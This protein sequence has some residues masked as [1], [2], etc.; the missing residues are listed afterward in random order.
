MTEVAASAAPPPKAGRREW[1]GLAVLA[2]PAMLI[3]MDMTVLYLAVPALSADLAPTSSQLLWILDIYAFLVAGFL[4]T[5]GSLGDRI[6]RRKL[7][8]IGAAAFGLASVV[9]AYAPNAELLI[10]ARALLGIAGATL[11][12]STLALIRNMFH[13]PAQRA[14]AIAVWMTAFMVGMSIGPLV[15]GAFLSNFWWGSVFLMAVPAMVLLLAAAP[16]LLPEHKDPAPGRLDGWSLLLSVGAMMTLVYGVK[17]IAKDGIAVQPALIALLGVALG[18]VFVLRQRTLE[19]PLLDLKLF[20]NRKFS[21]SLATMTLVLFAMAGMYLFMAQYLQLILGMSPFEAGLWTL[22]QTV[23]MMVVGA[24][25]P[26]LVKKYRPAYVMAAGLAV[27]VVGCSLYTQLDG[28]Q[29]GLLIVGNV[30]FALGL[31]PMTIMGTDMILGA[32]EPDKAG[33]A[34]AVSETNQELGNALGVALLGSVGTAVYRGHLE[35]TMPQ[36][37]DAGTAEVALDTL[38]GALASAAELPGRAG[39]ALAD[40][41]R[42]AFT[43]GLHFNAVVSAT[44]IAGAAVL[45]AVLLKHVQPVAQDLAGGGPEQDPAA[46][47]GTAEPAPAVQD[48]AAKGSQGE[49]QAPSGV[50]GAPS[51]EGELNPVKST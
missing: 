36:G 35:D 38:G 34:S 39:E 11:M 12:P 17:E 4:M 43:E 47:K 6:G 18:T 41:A 51:P 5:M 23:A 31:G 50:A 42:T 33:I 37:V 16:V 32:V 28:G 26:G 25:T 2:L 21:A 14:S 44:L 45:V 48:P 29:L 8:I 9:A 46:A 15:G 22:P 1:V 30:I 24:V 19:A 3:S 27:A 40:A 7:L 10:A 13:D 20:A 49:V